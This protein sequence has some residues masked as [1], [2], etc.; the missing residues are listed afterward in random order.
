MLPD[1]STLIPPPH[2]LLYRTTSKKAAFTRR[3]PNAWNAD[4][5][6]ELQQ[7]TLRVSME[8]WG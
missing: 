3:N 7:S 6:M 4:A 8:K 5:K 2:G 1:A